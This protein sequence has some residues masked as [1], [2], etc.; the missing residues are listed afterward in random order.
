M[1]VEMYGYWVMK[2]FVVVLD[3]KIRCSWYIVK[4]YF[5]KGY[6]YSIVLFLFDLVKNVIYVNFCV[7][8]YWF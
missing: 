3:Y 4:D 8:Y 1:F 7:R 5:K 2:K 6:V